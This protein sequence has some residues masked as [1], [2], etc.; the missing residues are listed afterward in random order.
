M[1]TFDARQTSWEGLWHNPETLAYT[2]AVFDI[3]LLQQFSGPVRLYVRKNMYYD[4]YDDE[5]TEPY[6]NFMIRDANP[7]TAKQIQVERIP[8]TEKTGKVVLRKVQHIKAL[9]QDIISLS[10]EIPQD[11]SGIDTEIT[12]LAE[13]AFDEI[14]K[15]EEAKE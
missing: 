13:C 2:S 12:R 5:C 7:K 1:K 4:E 10:Y 8:K 14:K 3:S 15:L 6:Y 9:L 11:D